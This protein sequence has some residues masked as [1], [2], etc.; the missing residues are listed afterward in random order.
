M[1]E[2]SELHVDEIIYVIDDDPISMLELKI[3]D[4]GYNDEYKKRIKVYNSEISFEIDFDDI[5]DRVF[6]KKDEAYSVAVKYIFDETN[7][8]I[9]TLTGGWFDDYF[10]LDKSLEKYKQKYPE[11]FI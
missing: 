8:Y 1:I 9:R 10:E 11:I 3:S 5:K 2:F 4:I 7:K 6:V